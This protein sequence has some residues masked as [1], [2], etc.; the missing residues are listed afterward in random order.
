MRNSMVAG[1]G[2][3]AV[4]RCGL[5]FSPVVCLSAYSLSSGLL[6][7]CASAPSSLTRLELAQQVAARSTG[8]STLVTRAQKPEAEAAKPAPAGSLLD[9]SHQEFQGAQEGEVTARIRAT[10]NG[11]PILDQEVREAVRPALMETRQLPEPER[12]SRQSEIIQQQLEHIIDRELIIQEAFGLL[13]QRPQVLDKLKQ[14]AGKEADR[15][16]RAMKKRLAQQ[17]IE[18]PTE[19]EFR[20]FLHSQG[21]SLESMRRRMEREYMA[22]E[23]MS[24][25]IAPAFDRIGH[26]SILEYYQQHPEEFQVPDSVK[27]QDI[28]IDASKFPNRT[29]ARQLA[30]QLARQ[31]RAGEDFRQLVMQ[32]D[33]GDS[34]YRNGEGYGQR[35]GEIK[36][37]QAEPML[38]R[39]PEGEIDILELANGY[40][41]IRLV[42]RDY[43]GQVPLDD[44]TQA[45][46]RNKLKAQVWEREYKRIVSNLKRKAAIEISTAAP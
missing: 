9:V 15:Q 10:V 22:M 21:M 12:R 37:P 30:D 11:V 4:L 31:G 32:H 14:S 25:R 43:A 44:K 40:H 5:R 42:K 39:M 24:S 19:A 18:V 1:K 45:T 34:S 2:R 13:K 29:Q 36:P 26:E 8:E 7:G 20:A 38:F 23:W 33:D 27:W 6:L 46:I 41:V 28:F 3:A 17:G 16:L 35:R